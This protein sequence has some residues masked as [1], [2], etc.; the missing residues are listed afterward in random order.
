MMPQALFISQFRV[1]VLCLICVSECIKNDLNVWS[2]G[3]E[4]SLGLMSCISRLR[5]FS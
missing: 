3:S 5:L 1:H 4:G 2:L